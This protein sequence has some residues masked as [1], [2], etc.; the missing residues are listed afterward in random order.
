MRLRRS[1]MTGMVGKLLQSLG[2]EYSRYL[3]IDLSGGESG[4]I[5]KWFLW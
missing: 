2:G 4:E 5:C 1:V 3:G